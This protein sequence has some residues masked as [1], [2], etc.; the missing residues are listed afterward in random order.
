[1]KK[2]PVGF[3]TYNEYLNNRFGLTSNQLTDFLHIENNS[4]FC[5]DLNLLDVSQKWG[6]PLEIGFT[7]LVARQVTNMYGYFAQSF[8]RKGYSGKFVY[9]YASKAAQYEDLI[10]TALQAG[11]HYET[12]SP[13]DLQM[14]RLHWKAG[15]LPKDRYILSNGFKTPEYIRN[16]VQLKREG[17]RGVVPIVESETEIAP[18]V[19]TGLPFEVGIRLRVDRSILPDG[20]FSRVTSRFG[21]AHD[22]IMPTAAQIAATPN[23]TPV[24]FHA[25]IDTQCADRQAWVQALLLSFRFYCELKQQYPTM[26]AFN[27]GGGMPVPYSLD[28]QFDYQ[29]FADELTEGVMALC[30]EYGVPHPDIFGEFGRYTAAAYG[31]DFYKVVVSKPS[32]REDVGWYVIDGSLMSSLPDTWALK[33]PFI[34]LPLNGYDKPTKK[35]WLSGLTCDSDDVYRSGEEDD[36]LILPDVD[37]FEDGEELVIGVFMTGAYQDM[38]SG[39][40]GVHHCLLPEPSELVIEPAANGKGYNYTRS[41]PTQSVYAMATLLGYQRYLPLLTAN[42]FGESADGGTLQDEEIGE[43]MITIAGSSVPGKLTRRNVRA[44]ALF[45]HLPTPLRNRK[46]SLL[47]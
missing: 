14:A 27:F 15:N 32:H 46:K 20:D 11:A 34:I 43:D 5:Q 30:A 42:K 16:M 1:M 31:F 41:V 9:A 3:A 44:R 4:L 36:A 45:R 18:L 12:S 23:L 13:M 22:R 10:R 2:N 33:Q 17:F 28:F 19:K 26:R 47:S 21:V 40:G 24:M 29:A 25:M 38:L 8:A 35:V 6:S 39:I 7:P 37:Y